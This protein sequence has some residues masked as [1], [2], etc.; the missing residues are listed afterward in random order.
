MIVA[1][2]L[3]MCSCLGSPAPTPGPAARP[4]ASPGTW[5]E[6][7]TLTGDITGHATVTLPDAGA[8]TST[9]SGKHSTAGYSL[10]LTLSTDQG[11]FQL[12]VN[13]PAY[14]SPGT[15]TNGGDSRQVGAGIINPE[16]TSS[17]TSVAGDAVTFTVHASQESGT[18]DA[19]FGD[20]N[21][22]TAIRPETVR[23]T[24]TCRSGT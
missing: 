15:Y 13:V 10:I 18:I 3:A 24:W 9:C 7:L 1:A 23:G 4:T 6:D 8:T 17:W 19:T 14:R 20:H 12:F 11:V 16:R 2:S 21:H 22:Q 5:P